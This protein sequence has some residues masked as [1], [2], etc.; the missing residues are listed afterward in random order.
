MNVL[1]II[2]LQIV[3]FNIYVANGNSFVYISGKMIV[4]DVYIYILCHSIRTQAS[5]LSA[6]VSMHLSFLAKIIL[7]L[8]NKFLF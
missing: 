8:K 4:W 3:I 7:F 1:I 2:I 5:L 6:V